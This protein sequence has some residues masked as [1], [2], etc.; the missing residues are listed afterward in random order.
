MVIG[1]STVFTYVPICK[2]TDLKNKNVRILDEKLII[3]LTVIRSINLVHFALLAYFY[4]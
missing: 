1:Y 3:Y 2:P 4:K